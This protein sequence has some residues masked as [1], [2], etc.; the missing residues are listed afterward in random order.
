MIIPSTAQKNVILIPAVALW[1]HPLEHIIDAMHLE[2][3]RQ[4]N[5]R[6]MGR[7]QAE[8][9]A[10]PL[11][12][13]VGVHVVDCSVILTAVAIGTA[14]CILEHARSV[15]DGMNQVVGQK[16]RDGTIDG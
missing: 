5:E 16:Q 15:V 13:E 11:A 14:H 12:V 10:T 7:L 2:I 8:G 9:A 3:A 6:H 1:A 4:G